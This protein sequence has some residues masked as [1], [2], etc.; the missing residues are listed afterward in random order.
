MDSSFNKS[1]LTTLVIGLITAICG[2]GGLKPLEKLESLALYATMLI[3]AL[4]LGGVAIY[5]IN[6]FLDAGHFVL[7]AMPQR[8]GWE[9]VTIVAGTLIV[10]QG[11]ETPR[12]ILAAVSIPGRE[13]GLHCVPE[14]PRTGEVFSM[15]QS[16]AK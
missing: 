16:V 14:S 12:A 5:D 11:F 13:Y 6:S 1:L 4:L 3:L 15:E 10:V 7:P 9:M 8:S 2:M